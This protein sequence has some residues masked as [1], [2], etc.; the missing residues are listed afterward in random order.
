MENKDLKEKI[1]EEFYKYIGVNHAENT[2]RQVDNIIEKSKDIDFPEE[3][4]TW[5]D[6]YMNNTIKKDRKKK[7]KNK[8]NS[9]AKRVAI[10]LTVLALGWGVTTF[11]VEANR[12]RFFNIVTEITKEYTKINIE[13]EPKEDISKN[14]VLKKPYF[15]PGYIPMGYN[16]SNI[17]N[18]DQ[19]RLIHFENE[20]RDIIEFL[21]TELNPDFQV[22]TE[23]ATTEEINI[24]GS[25]GFFVKKRDTKTLIWFTDSNTFYIIGNLDEKEIITMAESLEFIK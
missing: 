3:L 18:F 2:A 8:V 12:I 23:D 11:S 1:F 25:K 6:G 13:R 16:Q 21:Q 19:L 10:F 17:Q 9:I 22:D 14:T 4:D 15:Y 7:L 20:N 24:N 5:F